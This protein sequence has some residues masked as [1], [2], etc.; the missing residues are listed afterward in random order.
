MPGMRSAET[1]Y[2]VEE[3]EEKELLDEEESDVGD[4][5][6]WAAYG[7]LVCFH[8]SSQQALDINQ[9]F[10]FMVLGCI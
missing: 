7:K 2:N 10:P 1:Q 4:E 5:K 6:D 9:G 3:K 8:R